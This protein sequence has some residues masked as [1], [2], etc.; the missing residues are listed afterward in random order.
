M[1]S[2]SIGCPK[3]D[4]PSNLIFY[5]LSQLAFIWSLG[6]IK[7]RGNHW[8][9]HSWNCCKTSYSFSVLFA[10]L[11]WRLEPVSSCPNS[12]ASQQNSR[13]LTSCE[14]VI[15]CC[16][17]WALR[18]LSM[19]RSLRVSDALEPKLTPSSLSCAWSWPSEVAN[20]EHVSP[21]KTSYSALAWKMGTVLGSSVVFWL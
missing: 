8:F 15:L 21:S 20:E 9:S 13:S 3:I 10:T 12:A 7:T 11:L 19:M 6:A 1:H 14:R 2:N 4:S 16:K 17:F 18:G 5:W